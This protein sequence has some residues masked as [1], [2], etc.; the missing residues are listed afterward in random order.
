MR[1]A[2]STHRVQHEFL[3]QAHNDLPARNGRL[4]ERL[5]HW[6]EMTH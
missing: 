6:L 2:V 1:G 4:L 5:A 3:V